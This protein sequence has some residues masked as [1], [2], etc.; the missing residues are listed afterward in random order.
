MEAL[1]LDV[2]HSDWHDWRG[3]GK[4]EDRLVEP[5]WVEQL[6][7]RWGLPVAGPPDA[8]TI[9]ALRSLRSLMQRIVHALLQKQ[10]PSE[11]D[12][13]ALDTYLEGTPTRWHLVRTGKHYQLQQVS[14]H[15]DWNEVLGEV[16]LS[17]TRLLV[18]D[19][20]RIK[21]CENPDCR[22][23]Y[24]DESANQSRRW[25]EDPCANL[26]RVRRFRARRRGNSKVKTGEIF[27]S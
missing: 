3:R 12:L 19:P 14:L 9:A 27:T 21:Q 24:Y 2:L 11:Q 7:I 1:C 17:F 15:T 13:A 22:W 10:E 16:A 8:D 6:V 25:C 23:I 20:S 26:M 4:D 18:R 5:G